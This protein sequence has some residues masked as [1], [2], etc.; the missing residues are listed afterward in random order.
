MAYFH[1]ILLEL[2][3]NMEIIDSLV[4][5][6]QETIECKL[7]LMKAYRITAKKKYISWF[8]EVNLSISKRFPTT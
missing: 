6:L 4:H 3:I 5:V 8:K 2:L 7:I 1:N